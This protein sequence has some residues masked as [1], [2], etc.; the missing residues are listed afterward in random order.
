LVDLIIAAVAERHR[1][2]I[3]HFDADYDRI[4]AL[5]GQPTR[6]VTSH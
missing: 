6:W 4:A 1:C 5:S 3:V 2:P